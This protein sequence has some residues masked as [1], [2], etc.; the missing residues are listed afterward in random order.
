MRCIQDGT[1]RHHI[2]LA[3][4]LARLD[5]PA[6]FRQFQSS[7][8]VWISENSA[9]NPERE[10]AEIAVFLVFRRAGTRTNDSPLR[11]RY[12]GSRATQ[13][14]TPAHCSDGAAP[15]PSMSS[16]RAGRAGGGRGRSGARPAA[17]IVSGPRPRP[18]PNSWE[19]GCG[20]AARVGSGSWIS[21]GWGVTGSR[22]VAAPCRGWS[23]TAPT[24]AASPGKAAPSTNTSIWTVRTAASEFQR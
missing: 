24:A 12:P 20:G 16:W 14:T 17:G 23:A 18:E 4:F 3:A 6:G 5:F 9:Q 13:R 19:A 10:I 21:W 22:P 11:S 7:L 2:V 8:R 1:S 15:G